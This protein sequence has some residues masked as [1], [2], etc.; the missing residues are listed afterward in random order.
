MIIGF[1][2]SPP[3]AVVL[4]LKVF[5]IIANCLKTTQINFSSFPQNFLSFDSLEFSLKTFRRKTIFRSFLFYDENRHESRNTEAGK[6]N[7]LLM[8]EYLFL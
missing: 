6:F 7:S 1:S 2:Q 8:S 3:H 4:L 5:I